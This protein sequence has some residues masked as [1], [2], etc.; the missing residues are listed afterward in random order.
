MITHKQ[1]KPK[2]GLAL[3]SGSARGWAHIGVIRALEEQGI[4]PDIITGC[5]IGSLVGMGT[6]ITMERNSRP[7]GYQF[8]WRRVS[9]G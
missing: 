1:H 9:Q 3:G 5:S 8:S 2:I 6:A 7:D 4:K